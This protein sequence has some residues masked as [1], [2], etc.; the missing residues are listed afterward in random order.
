MK[1]RQVMQRVVYWLRANVIQTASSQRRVSQD[2][3]L[4]VTMLVISANIL[5][6]HLAFIEYYPLPPAARS[7]R[8]ERL[9]CK[10]DCHRKSRKGQTNNWSQQGV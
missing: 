5:W 6:S 8:I 7:D 4:S 1:K 10:L 9:N 2:T 3:P